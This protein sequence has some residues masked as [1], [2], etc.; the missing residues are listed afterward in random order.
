MSRFVINKKMYDTEKAT[1]LGDVDKWYKSEFFSNFYGKDV[2][3]TYVCKLYRTDKNNYFIVH[4][5]GTKVIG[6]AIS[7][8]QAKELLM[9]TNPD[10]YV[11]YFGEIEE[12]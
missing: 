12:A 2:G 8:E 5:E 7:E 9:N 11:I 6:Q 1:Y 3:T 4:E 10:V